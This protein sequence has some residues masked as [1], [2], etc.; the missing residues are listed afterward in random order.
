MIITLNGAQENFAGESLTVRELLAAKRW[1]F[2]LIVVKVN[3]SLVPKSSWDST[4]ITEGD[5]VEAI[6]LMSGG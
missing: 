2:P 5:R 4:T 3:G 6:H 1:S